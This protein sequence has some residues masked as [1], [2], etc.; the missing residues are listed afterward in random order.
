MY[1]HDPV[2]CLW[3]WPRASLKQWVVGL[4]T[5]AALMAVLYFVFSWLGWS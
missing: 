2:G 5:M 1:D 3:G 4:G